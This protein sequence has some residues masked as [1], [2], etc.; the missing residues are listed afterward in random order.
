M[1]GPFLQMTNISKSFPG[2][3]ALDNVNLN[4]ARGTVHTLLGENGAGKS[5]LVKILSGVHQPDTGTIKMD[6]KDVFITSTKTAEQVGIAIIYQELNLIP[7]MTVAENIFLGREPKTRLGLVDYKKMRLDATKELAQLEPEINPN[8]PVSQLRI[9][10]QQLVEIAKALSL[11][12]KVLIMDEPTSA[13]TD[14]E[15]QKLF[16]V[17][18]GL[19]KKR[20]GYHLYHSQA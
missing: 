9:G 20:C 7:Q 1:S 13:L 15:A 16:N 10:Q 2:V 12:A 3:K 14:T 8:T 6:D 11:H 18:R 19:Q 5:T 17:I 4:V